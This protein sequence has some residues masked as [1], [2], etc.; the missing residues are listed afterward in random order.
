MRKAAGDV[1][2]RKRVVWGTGQSMISCATS[3]VARPLAA[4]VLAS[5]PAKDCK[6][7]RATEPHKA[8]IQS[9]GCNTSRAWYL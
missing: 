7:T 5:S 8:P 6:A 1:G 9:C 2:L 4:L 3:F